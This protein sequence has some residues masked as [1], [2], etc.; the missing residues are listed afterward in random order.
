[1]PGDAALCPQCG[2]A[3][4]SGAA[5]SSGAVQSSGSPS[6]WGRAIWSGLLS[7]VMPGLGQVHAR[8][9]RLGV[10]LL[11]VTMAA[12][13]ALDGL[14]QFRPEPT[15]IA[16]SLALIAAFVLFALGAAADAVRRTRGT[17]RFARPPW[18]RSTWFTA[19]VV[20]LLDVAVGV[21]M[22]RGW[23]SFSIPSGAMLPTILIGDRVM[24]DTRPTRAPPAYG[25]MVIFKYPRDKSIN[26]IKRIV[27]L[28]GDR[29]QLRQGQLFIN[30]EIVPRQPMADYVTDDFGMHM[31][32]HRYQEVLP[33]GMKATILKVTDRGE[34][35]NTPEYLV[36]P[37]HL[38]VLGDN[39]DNSADSRFMNGVGFVPIE[40]LVGRVEILTSF[41][42]NAE[43]PWW[44]IWEWPSEIR[45][46][47]MM[48]PVN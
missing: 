13:V 26:Y 45:W 18:F 42:V 28:P 24:V 29:I 1:V 48:R 19:V 2:A 36:P 4:N 21:V 12:T 17:I 22:P 10:L 27:G 44:Q 47:Q 25:D 11:G 46:D 31:V 5:Q 43:Y 3:Q 8:S 34:M 35:N 39:R 38:F 23:R 7:F 14:S 16:V 37:D 15:T 20:L 40:N 32:A 33:G 6:G 30:R 41:S 9:W